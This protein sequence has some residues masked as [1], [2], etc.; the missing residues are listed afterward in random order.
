VKITHLEWII[1]QHLKEVMNTGYGRER[2]FTV[3]LG[4]ARVE[5]DWL[6]AVRLTGCRHRS[7]GWRVRG[8][9]SSSEW[10]VKSMVISMIST[11]VIIKYKN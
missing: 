1:H 4:A 5:R 7:H 6:T 9:E 3:Q 11:K 2:D 8:R 10:P